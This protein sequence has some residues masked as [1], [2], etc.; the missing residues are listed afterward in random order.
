MLPV[1]YHAEYVSPLPPGHRFPM[2]KFGLLYQQLQD[3][4]IASLENT[5]VP[6]RASDDDL[7]LVHTPEYVR[8]FTEGTL[9]HQEMRRIGL[10]WSEEL[11]HRT[12]RAVGG[13][14]LTAR[15]A[16]RHGL[17]VNTA[18]GTHHAHPSFGSGFCIFNDLA[19][20]ARRLVRD[21]SAE[22]V[23]IFDLDV[24]QGDGTAAA[25]SSDIAVFSADVH[26]AENFPFRKQ[27]GGIDVALP[28]GTSDRE[29][30]STVRDVLDRA[31]DGIR[32]DLV[33]Y[34]AGVDIFRGDR[35]GKLQVS[36]KGIEERDRL[37]LSRLVEAGIPVAAVIGGGYQQDLKRLVT[38]H[39]ILHR[40]AASL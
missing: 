18:G 29:Y 36:E 5:H 28:A 21:R 39:A 25:V 17:A 2:E 14:L 8:S 7:L 9:S 11:V 16:L 27:T 15:L 13:T 40:V 38:L 37:V 26:C 10:P 23:L 22:T 1:V 19:V 3:E 35:L 24:H 33:L 12:K 32:P 6:E 30:L 34:D 31:L 20:A 4:R